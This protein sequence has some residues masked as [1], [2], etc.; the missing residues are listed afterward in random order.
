MQRALGGEVVAAMLAKEGV[1]KVFGIVDGTYLGLYASFKKYGIELVSPRHETSAAHMAGA[2]ARLTGKLGVCIASNGP[3]VAN[4]LPGIAVENGEGNRVLVITSSRRQGI[5]YPDRGGTFQYFDQ[6][7]VTRPMTKW[8]GSAATFERIPE[9]M[10]RAFRVAHR[11]RPGVVHV[12]VPEN[13]MNGAYDL[14]PLAL[15][16]PHE[17]RRTD[18]IAPPG[19]VVKQIADLLRGAERP[20]IHAG[21]GVVHA[22]AFEALKQVAEALQAPVST[23]WGGRGALPEQHALSL[24]VSAM[25]A[26]NQARTSADV[27]LVIGSRLGETDWWGKPPYWGR[28]GEQRF[29]QV[30]LDEEILGLNR[31]TE[32]A[33]QADAK[34]FLEALAAELAKTPAKTSGRKAWLDSISETKKKTRGE[35]DV[36]LQNDATPMH[37]AHVPATVR[38]MVP[39]DTVIVA[40]GGNTAV[41][42]Q[43]FSDVRTPN[44]LLGTFKL[45]MLGAGVGQALGAQVAHPE[46]RVVCI[47]GDGAM[48]FHCQELETAVRHEL[49]VVFVV[50]CDKQWGMVKLTQQFALGTAR[51]VI[52]VEDQGTINTDFHE[53]RFDDLARSMG[54]HGE[55][56]AAPGELEAALARAFAAKKAAVVHVDV[57]PMLHLWAPGLQAFKDMHQEPAG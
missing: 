57:D 43:F 56:V 45:G 46:R 40:D 23:S 38:R 41:W 27:V 31:P 29:I 1:E 32:L 6:V 9:V 14:E 50:L 21:S 17:Y 42:T 11:G 8:S 4:I 36:A 34:A 48:G 52:G 25:E 30:D 2:Y 35:L 44:T 51:E 18:A 33:V 55:R 37:P 54:A 49:P 24:P 53:V 16:E 10:R 39:D 19:V 12:D 22:Q 5:T 13:V 26:Q 15:R 28:V 20:L 7:A 3:G 47:L